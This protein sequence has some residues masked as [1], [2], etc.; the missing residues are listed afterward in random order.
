VRTTDGWPHGPVRAAIGQRP[1]AVGREKIDLMSDKR[2]VG[3]GARFG[4]SPHFFVS[5]IPA[6][7]NYLNFRQPDNRLTK[8]KRHPTE[9]N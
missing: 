3:V 4:L 8:V 9:V 6:D 2:G 5:P 7:E 1:S